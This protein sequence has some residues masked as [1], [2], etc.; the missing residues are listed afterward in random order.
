MKVLIV[1]DDSL[2]RESLSLIL[3]CEDDITVCGMAEEGANAIKMCQI[4]KPDVV[5]MDIRMPNMDG[6]VAT[7]LIKKEYPTIR[8]MMLTTFDDKSNIQQALAAGA[9]GYLLKTDDLSDIANKLRVFVGGVGILD[10]G[11]IKKLTENPNLKQL[12]PREQ[13]ITQLV[14]QG[15]TNKE[16]ATQLFLSEKTVR[17]N[18]TIIMEKLNV[19]NRTQLGVA[20]H[21]FI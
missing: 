13:E 1:D 18:I 10:S 16:I 4:H 20:Y 6:V 8:I 9:E 14:A 7:R 15:L 19:S 17:N 21:S 11:V 2:I 5:L 3:T 12:T